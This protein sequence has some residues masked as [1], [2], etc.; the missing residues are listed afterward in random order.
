MAIQIM[1][2]IN[3]SP[4]SFSGDGISSD[5]E[6]ALKQRI[7]TALDNGAD[8]LDIG[9]QS[10]RPGAVTISVQ[11]EIRRTIPAIN[12]ARQLTDK[13]ISIDTFKPE[14]AKAALSAGA[15]IINDITGCR[16][17]KMVSLVKTSGCEVVIMHM[18]GTPETMSSMTDYPKGV[19]AEVKEFLFQQTENLSEAGIN[20]KNI[21]LDPGIGF[22]KTATQS[23]ELTHHF[24]EFTQQ[25]Y[26]VLYGAS[27]K[28]FI[29][30]ALATNG[31][32]AP[33]P[34]RAVGTVVV[35]TYAMMHGAD[36]IRVHDVAAAAQTRTVAEAIMG[37][38]EITL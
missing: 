21:I 3:T 31:E 23:F 7:Q 10:T 27:N 35:Q 5:N 11:E 15:T 33:V 38:R 17:P 4:D 24:E 29:G 8:I 22:A 12:I 26:R 13:P 30:K 14:V 20:P 36:I 6:A 34:D 1:A 32:V 37:T 9:G 16:D 28:S 18:R 2:I 19:V 25:G